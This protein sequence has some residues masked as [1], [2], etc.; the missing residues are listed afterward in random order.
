ML[1][2]CFCYKPLIP[3]RGRAWLLLVSAEVMLRFKG[4]DRLC[5]YRHELGSACKFGSRWA[6]SEAAWLG[7]AIQVSE[8]SCILSKCL[9]DPSPQCD[10]GCLQVTL[11]S[12]NL[13]Y[14]T[15]AN[16]IQTCSGFFWV[17]FLVC[18]VVVFGCFFLRK[19][20]K[21]KAKDWPG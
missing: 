13:Q 3:S 19:K 6:D 4:E 11:A 10:T 16:N 20:K 12:C 7:A 21:K 9:K 14:Y 15:F 5:S 18:L 17:F 2:L 8:H 1:L